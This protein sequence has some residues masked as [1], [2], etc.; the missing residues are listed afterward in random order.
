MR[1]DATMLPPERVMD[2]P[3]PDLVDGKKF[4][5]GGCY[6]GVSLAGLHVV[7]GRKFGTE[8]LPLFVSLAEFTQRGQERMIPFSVGPREII[9]K[10]KKAGELGDAGTSTGWIELRN[11]RMVPPT[12]VGVGDLSLF[13]GLYSVPGSDIVRTLLDV[14]GDLSRSAG[15][16]VPLA[17]VSPATD[18][19]KA[20]YAGFGS[21]VGAT[22]LQAL[23]QAENGRALPGTGSGYLVVANTKAG[24]L[25]DES[26]CV[27]GGKLCRG[28]AMVVDFDYCLVAIERYASV[29]E[30]ATGIAPDLFAS[31]WQDVLKALDSGES[32]ASK[33]PM[34]KL[35]AAVRGTP[36]L[37]DAD[38]AAAM[39]AYLQ[40]YTEEVTLAGKI[41]ELTRGANDPLVSAVTSALGRKTEKNEELH[42]NVSTALNLLDATPTTPREFREKPPVML[43]ADARA[44]LGALDDTANSAL[45]DVLLRAV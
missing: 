2:D 37:I 28:D 35:L 22:S 38:R 24:T 10:L 17:A 14:V 12:P 27:R 16:I 26:I 20:V 3:F 44:A 5:S 31:E 7:E 41:Q 34:R 11:L 42:R 30:E 40:R 39:T 13:V 18:V 1:K 19:A 21:L 6:F 36:A 29:L 8:R 15:A 33:A 25:S 45:A 43:A 32:G 23:A 9:D 4:Q